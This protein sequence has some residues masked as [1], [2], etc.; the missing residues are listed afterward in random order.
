MKNLSPLDFLDEVVAL[1]MAAGLLPQL[2]E[3]PFDELKIDQRF[4]H[5]AYADTSRCAALDASLGLAR[6]LNMEA[7]AEG[8]EDRADWD[9]LLKKKCDVAQG[10]YISK[11]LPASAIPDW[12]DAWKERYSSSV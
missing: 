1:T 6:Q 9:F 8:V 7:V 5:R 3:T 2:T 11:P 10:Y 12:V 4:V